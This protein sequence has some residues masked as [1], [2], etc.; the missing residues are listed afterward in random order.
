MVMDNYFIKQNGKT[1]WII[2]AKEWIFPSSLALLAF[3]IRSAGLG[4]IGY[5][6]DEIHSLFMAELSLSDYWANPE[7]IDHPPLYF[8]IVSF[9]KLASDNEIWIRLLS[10]IFGSLAV[11]PVYAIG[12]MLLNREAGLWAALFL[13][14]SPFHFR[15]SQEAR[16]YALLFLL[17]AMLLLAALHVAMKPDRK[18]NWFYIGFALLVI[19][20]HNV[21]V[22]FVFCVMG[23]TLAV[24]R[25]KHRS[26]RS[27]VMLHAALL[28][29]CLPILWLSVQQSR[30]KL[31]T[32]FWQRPP[33][34][35]EILAAVR[36]YL[37]FDL[38]TL[39][40][41][42]LKVAGW[43]I[44][45]FPIDMLAVT[46]F[47]AL[48]ALS[49]VWA[50]DRK[51]Y[52]FSIALLSVLFFPILLMV[53]SWI[54]VPVFAARTA[55]PALI[56]VPLLMGYAPAVPKRGLAKMGVRALAI[57]C[58]MVSATSLY[59]DYKTL[60]KEDWRG[61]VQSLTS[62]IEPDDAILYWNYNSGLGLEYYA[63]KAGISNPILGLPQSYRDAFYTPTLHVSHKGLRTR[64]ERF[65]RDHLRVWVA[66]F[67][68]AEGLNV[69][70]ENLSWAGFSRKSTA[71]FISVE[72]DL[73][74]RPPR[75]SIE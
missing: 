6:T 35:E 30:F 67:A 11:F 68:G 62:Q 55:I 75:P 48:A 31:Q 45:Y 27:W 61:L 63:R 8:L 51:N 47:A 13:V 25:W 15:Y 19:A 39:D 58:L 69:L 66:H 14:F 73:F 18:W 22:V 74:V 46:A 10:A 21:G 32:G 40:Y 72:L 42:L 41:I 59:L 36:T 60:K 53:L 57:L 43:D 23:M 64:F 9:W 54:S 70:D 34:L 2:P 50:V 5:W 3:L 33:G 37:F 44:S 28:I 24:F 49:V 20:T 16:G 71:Q 56:A 1:E 4:R 29:V 38:P 52:F 17:C 12:R 7:P 26:L 65:S